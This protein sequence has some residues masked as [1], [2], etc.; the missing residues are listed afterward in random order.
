L[1][2][3]DLVALMPLLAG[4]GLL[5]GGLWQRRQWLDAALIRR[6]WSGRAGAF[7]AGLGSGLLVASVFAFFWWWAIGGA[8]L[9]ATLLAAALV[10]AG[11]EDARSRSRSGRGGA[12]RGRP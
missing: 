11:S 5:A 4:I 10:A 1:S 6:P 2:L 12:G 9:T 3:V 8:L 7:V